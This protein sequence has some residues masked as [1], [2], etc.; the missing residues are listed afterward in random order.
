MKSPVL[1]II[2]V[3]FNTKALTEQTIK[4][5]FDSLVSL[6]KS[7][8]EILVIDN[9][10]KDGSPSYLDKI[11]ENKIKIIKNEENL[12]FAKANNLG[13][14]LAEGKYVLLLNSDTIVQKSALENLLACIE[15]S[16]NRGMVAASL[17]NKDGSY[18]PQGGA[19]P[20]L[21]SVSSW[22]L[23]PVPGIAPG[24]D[25]YQDPRPLGEVDFAL[26]GWVGGTA[27]LMKRSVYEA[28]GGLD[29]RI[30]MYAEDVDLC[31]RIHRSGLKVGICGESKIVHLGS[32][33]SS[34]S[35]ARLMELKGLIYLFKKY[36]SW[37]SLSI[38]RLVLALGS[39]LRLFY[40]GILKGN[41]E[42]RSLYIHSV[43]VSFK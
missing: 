17:L 8:I 3:S 18:Q 32:A 13:V 12:G 20:N 9:G 4:S 21:W 25:H 7:E 5:I 24:S 35:R 10:S 16:P 27:L 36:N 43:L 2:I 14:K 30:F 1:S 28:I 34:S 40:F 11:F 22:W 26:R 41:S 33:S 29:E 19:L 6:K 23:W 39:V 38:L 15:R 37:L 31:K 42:A